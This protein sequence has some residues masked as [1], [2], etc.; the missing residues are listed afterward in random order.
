MERDP[1]WRTRGTSCT[2]RLGLDPDMADVVIS[3]A[4]LLICHT[5]LLLG[6]WALKSRCGTLGRTPCQNLLALSPAPE[7][8]LDALTLRCFV[9]PPSAAT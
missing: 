4:P 6:T 7:R 1:S 8:R 2:E 9:I 5:L 3:V